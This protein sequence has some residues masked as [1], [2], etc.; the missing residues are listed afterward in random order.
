MKLEPEGLRF[1]SSLFQAR[2]V[3]F[4]D[5][6]AAAGSTVTL[7]D[8]AVLP[9][10]RALASTLEAVV[11]GPEAN[12]QAF[13]SYVCSPFWA[14]ERAAR[15]LLRIATQLGASDIHLESDAAQVGVR[16][17]LAGD[18]V[19][20]TA[21]P[22]APG[23]RLV[24]A[25]KRLSGCL[26]YRRD[27]V[28]EGRI[29][30]EGVAADVRACFVPTSLGERVALRLFGQLLSLD[31]L[32]FPP[33]V[34]AAFERALRHDSGLVLIAGPSGAGK[35][36]TLYSALAAIAAQ[37]QSAHL[38]LEDPVEQRLRLAGIPVDQI[39]LSPE[40]GLTGEAALSAALRQDVDVLAVGELRTAAE[41][42]LA[43][44]AAHTGRLVLAGLH[45][46][47]PSEALQRMRDLDVD[48]KL[49]DQTVRAV[50]HQRLVTTA[51]VP[52]AACRGLG[53]VRTVQASLW[54][55]AE[56]G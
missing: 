49:L 21:L 17:R 20:F 46:G 31:Q 22:P 35:T 33:A 29:P 30:R 6:V 9:V 45:A 36:T 10:P 23:N 40:Q 27:V 51:C 43:V 8:G 25:L 41:A 34:R 13:L 18:V 3:P 52:C 11:A 5:V 48:P 19:P 24:A 12:A 15:A 4:D 39:E 7:A 2:F 53:R 47:S 32:G 28:Q 37:R 14:P 54:T 16:F 38:S 26:P 44:K 42:A 50:L 56:A 55:A 1:R